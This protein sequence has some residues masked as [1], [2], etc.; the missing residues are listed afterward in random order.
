MIVDKIPPRKAS[1]IN[2]SGWTFL[3]RKRLMAR[4]ARSAVRGT[5]RTESRASRGRVA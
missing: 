4:L 5:L 3:Y 2:G 1:K